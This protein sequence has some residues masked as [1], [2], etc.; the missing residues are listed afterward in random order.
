[1]SDYERLRAKQ[2]RIEA[3]LGEA[4]QRAITDLGRCADAL[5]RIAR[6][7]EHRTFGTT[8]EE[9]RRAGADLRADRPQAP[10]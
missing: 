2:D 3:A 10:E 8:V 9:V 5:E 4:D 1:V 6:A 7:L